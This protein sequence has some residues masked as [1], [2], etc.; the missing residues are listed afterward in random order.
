MYSTMAVSS[1]A[2]RPR[3]PEAYSAWDASAKVLT[4]LLLVGAFFLLSRALPRTVAL[5]YVPAAWGFHAVFRLS[6]IH[7]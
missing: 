1:F 7:I 2:A 4:G 6:L 5:L 3:K